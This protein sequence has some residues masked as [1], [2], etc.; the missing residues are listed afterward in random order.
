[1]QLGSTPA[2]SNKELEWIT[3]GI[4]NLVKKAVLSG[5]AYFAPQQSL[6][7]IVAILEQEHS[8]DFEKLTEN[9]GALTSALRIMFGSVE[10]V[11]ETRISRALA[12]DM[13]VNYDNRSLDE[14]ISMLKSANE[15]LALAR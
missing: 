1:M 10:S 5:L 7:V 9:I 6:E 13:G 12:K 8:V 2:K 15:T 14:L 4:D 11:V 3:T